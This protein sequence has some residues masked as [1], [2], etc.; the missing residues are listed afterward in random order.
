M[1]ANRGRAWLW[2]S[3]SLFSILF[4]VFHPFLW[5]WHGDS[6]VLQLGLKGY[7]STLLVFVGSLWFYAAR[8]SGLNPNRSLLPSISAHLAKNLGV[9]LIKIFQGFVD[10]LW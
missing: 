6:S 10:G 2:A 8:F 3:V 1:V 9:F 7:C 4:A 5:E